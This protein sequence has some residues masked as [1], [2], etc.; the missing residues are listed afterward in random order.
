VSFWIVLSWQD[1]GSVIFT[2]TGRNKNKDSAVILLITKKTC[3]RFF[4]MRLWK[5]ASRLVIKIIQKKKRE[6]YMAK[7]YPSY[8]Y[9]KMV[10]ATCMLLHR[11]IPLRSKWWSFRR[12]KHFHLYSSKPS[13][14]QSTL[15]VLI[16]PKCPLEREMTSLF[17]SHS[18]DT[19]G[20]ITCFG[21][22]ALECS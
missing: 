8:V 1:K 15:A 4:A 2:N 5:S 20:C 14:Q 7:L 11:S 12:H 17:H 3:V 6:E 16:Q 10:D 9:L 18:D 21:L 13:L 19:L 22:V